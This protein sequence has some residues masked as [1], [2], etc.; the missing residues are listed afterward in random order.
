M[1]MEESYGHGWNTPFHPED[2]QRAWV[3]WQRATQQN[4]RYS[5]ECRL[6]RADGLYRWWLIRGEPLRGANGEILKWFG[7]CTD[8]EDLKQAEAALQ[9]ANETLER[10]VAER[11]A[12]L[13]ES[14]DR[15]R[16]MANAM[17]Q[18]AWI[19]RAD[20]HLIWYNQRWYDY[21]GTTPEQM[22]GWGWQSVHDPVEL[23]KVLE[24]WKASIATGAPFEMTFPLRG[25]D[26]VFRLFLTRGFPLKD[27]A[28]QVTQWC[29]TNTDVN[30]LKRAEAA[31]RETQGRLRFALE[32]IQAGA[33][34]LD[35]VDHTAFRSM[36]HDRIFGYAEL[37]P[38]WTYEMFLE[39]VV[40]ED[41]TAVDGKFRRA[42]ESKGDWNFE[43]RIRRTDGEV[44]WILAAGRP[45][46]D[47]TGAPR[48]LAGIVQDITVRKRMETALRESEARHRLLAE[49]MLQGVVHQD[50]QG[51]IIAMN[52]AAERILGKAREQLLGSSSVREEQHTIREDGSLFPGS[53]HAAMVALR[54][55]QPVRGVVMGVWNPPKQARRWISIDAVPVFGSSGR[56]PSE[57]YTVFEDITERKRM[58]AAL[59]ESEQRYRAIGESLDYGVWVCAPDGRNLYASPSF[60]RLVGLTQQQCSD[61]GW[62]NVL[63]PDD[64]ERTIAAWKERVR[65]GGH[66]DIEHRFRGVDGRWHPI[67]ARGVAVRDEQGRITSWV[68]INLDISRLQRTEQALQEAQAKL[69]A[70]AEELAATV[71]Q[72][73]AKLQ[74]TVGD[75]EHFSY[76]ITHDMRAPLR[77]MQGFASMLEEDCGDSLSPP[78]RDYVRCIKAASDRLDRLI[79]DSLNYGK[80]VRQEITLE[81]V[82]LRDLI[83]GLVETYPNLQPDKADIEI[84]EGLPRVLGNQAALTQCFS[85]L[86]GNAVK[87]AKPG[88]KPRIR[89]WAEE[90]AEGEEHG[91][92]REE[93]KD[94]GQGTG[95]RRQET[96]VTR[97]STPA[98]SPLVRIWVEDDGIGI[99]K[100]CQARIFDLFQ[101]AT[102]THEGTGVG[103]AIVRKV[104]E[105]MGGRVGVESEEGQGSRFWVE[106]PLARKAEGGK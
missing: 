28:G 72:R 96:E 62:G 64:A 82:G 100:H 11:T 43:C 39:H 36:E 27:A 85:N 77:A 59:R 41:R 58:E 57:V 15:F 38:K 46:A 93:Q 80:T 79:A 86:L 14:E 32:T 95:D 52:P 4:E 35:L 87:F 12:A 13:R 68:G 6:R 54:T 66:W 17:P 103:L 53:E 65:T 10:R 19:A 9:E 78:G 49:T 67:L 75:L 94:G 104:V 98:L 5:L 40:P 26:G 42:M 18:L 30:E 97:H 21:T 50:A 89:V 22:E 90:G 51:T 20:G 73:T 47:A 63:H 102:T 71:A 16:T 3:A 69:Q 74:E 2:K 81:P 99:P 29:G 55:G 91:A 1:T 70:H 61:F 84:A 25:A 76:A 60:L 34:D 106:L 83:H 88:T 44:R 45:R 92:K 105:R 23:P 8:I 7:T 31:L 24:R 101:R 56:R 48:R 37:L 33:W